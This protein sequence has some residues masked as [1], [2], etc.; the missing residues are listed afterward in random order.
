MCIEQFILVG[1]L[2][3]EIFDLLVG[4]VGFVIG[5]ECCE[6]YVEFCLDGLVELVGFFDNFIVGG[7]IM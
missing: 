5:F 7:Y 3:G 4:G 6:E 2:S 1:Y